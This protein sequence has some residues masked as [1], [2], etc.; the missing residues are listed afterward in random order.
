MGLLREGQE[1]KAGSAIWGTGREGDII[2]LPSVPLAKMSFYL[3]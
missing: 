2:P 3:L 1:R